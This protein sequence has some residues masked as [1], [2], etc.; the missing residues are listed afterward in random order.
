MTSTVLSIFRLKGKED[1]KDV[2][3]KKDGRTLFRL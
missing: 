3:E 2:I 1:D